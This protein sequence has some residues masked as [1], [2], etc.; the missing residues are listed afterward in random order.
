MKPFGMP[1]VASTPVSWLTK[2]VVGKQTAF[3]DQLITLVTAVT[4]LAACFAHICLHYV[5]V[6]CCQEHLFCEKAQKT[7]GGGSA[8]ASVPRTLASAVCSSVA[9]VAAAAVAV[10][11]ALL[12]NPL[13]SLRFCD[14]QS[15][16]VKTRQ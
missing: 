2:A 1:C 15:L 14:V 7:S 8:A 12:I 3:K 13:Q 11:A 10:A 9:A 16:V 5:A 6:G 4:A